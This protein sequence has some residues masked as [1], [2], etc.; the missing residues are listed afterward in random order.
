MSTIHTHSNL[1]NTIIHEV[2]GLYKMETFNSTNSKLLYINKLIKRCLSD[3]NSIGWDYLFQEKKLPLKS[4]FINTIQQINQ[5]V[6]L[7]L[8]NGRI[9]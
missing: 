6:N 9:L 4:P 7:T 1:T 8:L 5:G 2:K 3:Q